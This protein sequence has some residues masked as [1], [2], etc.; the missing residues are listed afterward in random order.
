[1]SD[2]KVKRLTPN[3]IANLVMADEAWHDSLYV[4]AE[5]YD[6]LLADFEALRA[7]LA[8]E[9]PK[10]EPVAWLSRDEARLALWKAINSR[11][12]GNPTDDKLILDHLRQQGLWIGKVTSP[13]PPDAEAL[14]RDADRYR[15]LRD[16]APPDIGDMASVRDSHDP[17]EIDAAI[18]AAMKEDKT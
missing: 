7:H 11:E 15:W 10:Q 13:A 3:S 8:A 6:S 16:K 4:K 14:R 12:F 9:Q 5:D 18:D 1:M 2:R 17:S